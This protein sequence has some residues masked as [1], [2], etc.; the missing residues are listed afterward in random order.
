MIVTRPMAIPT[1]V[2]QRGSVL[3]L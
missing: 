3:K 1:A 2:F